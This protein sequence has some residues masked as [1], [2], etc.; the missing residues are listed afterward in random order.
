MLKILQHDLAESL[1]AREQNR[2]Q[3][4]DSRA[5]QHQK[6]VMNLASTVQQQ[7]VGPA[8]RA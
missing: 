7:Q 8:V 5:N 2:D 4:P 6:E 1:S 3:R